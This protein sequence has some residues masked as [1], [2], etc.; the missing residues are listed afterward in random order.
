[1][2]YP[3]NVKLLLLQIL[4]RRQQTLTHQDRSLQIGQ[5]LQEPIVDKEALQQFQSHKLVRMYSPELCTVS[6]RS[7]KGL[8]SELFQIGLPGQEENSEEPVTIIMLAEYYYAQRI[9]EIETL[10]MPE[11]RQQILHQLEN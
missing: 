1:M 8:V 11:L 2:D 6:T 5:L 10:Q 4:L 9:E 7:L 3:S